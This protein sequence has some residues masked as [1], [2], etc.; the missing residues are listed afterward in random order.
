MSMSSNYKTGILLQGKISEWT[1]DIIQ[2]YQKKFPSSTILLSTWTTDNIE[3]I[4]CEVLQVE[5][6]KKQSQIASYTINHQIIGTRAGLEKIECDIVMKCR[7][8]QFIHNSKIFEIFE[9]S[10]S[11]D[12]ILVPNGPNAIQEY[13]DYYIQ[14]FC[15]VAMLDVLLEYWNLMPFFDDP[16]LTMSPESYLTKNYLVKIK[17]DTRPWKSV[18]N[19]YFDI[20]SH[21]LDFQIEWEK[22]VKSESYRT[23]SKLRYYNDINY[24]QKK[25]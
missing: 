10:C 15:Q 1:I 11:K 21:N 5:P 22:L 13:V 8:D 20:R 7:T 23:D 16:H 2:E 9:T 18:M 25:L 3:N 24:V 12:K 6:P 19:D 17:K 14:D 4:P